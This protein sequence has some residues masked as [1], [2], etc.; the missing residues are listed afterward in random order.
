M[1]YNGSPT[2]F[3][4]HLRW[5]TWN[6]NHIARHQV[7]RDEVEEVC[8]GPYITREGYSGRIIV[9]GPSTAGRIL[10]AILE[11]VG[12]GVYYPVTARPASRKER[13]L[14]NQSKGGH[15]E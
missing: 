11:P 7:T 6:E 5:D 9:I 8:R 12:G 4:Q 14:Y 10:A 2:L 15:V 3:V 1:R 13:R